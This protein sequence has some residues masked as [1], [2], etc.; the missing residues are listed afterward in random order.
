MSQI[1]SRKKPGLPK[2]KAPEID[3]ALAC[4]GMFTR[5]AKEKGVSVS[6]ALKVAR[7]VRTS[8]HIEA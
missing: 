6:H 7:N 1:I 2:K 5:V 4:V 3:I 8:K